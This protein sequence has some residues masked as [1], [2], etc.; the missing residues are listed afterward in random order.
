[1]FAAPAL[2]RLLRRL[3]DERAARIREDERA[4]VA[5]HLHDSVLQSLVL[6]QRSDDPR[7]M[8]T[9]RPAPGA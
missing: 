3:D 2:G 1:M 6:I 5:A 7:R 8:T 9:H 4:I